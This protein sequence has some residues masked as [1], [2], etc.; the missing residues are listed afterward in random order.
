MIQNQHGPW[1]DL[2]LIHSLV[3][4]QLVLLAQLAQLSAYGALSAAQR[5]NLAAQVLLNLPAGLQVCLQLLNILLQSVPSGRVNRGG[6][7]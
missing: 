5:A 6:T 3:L 2:A 1:C 4:Q 7:R